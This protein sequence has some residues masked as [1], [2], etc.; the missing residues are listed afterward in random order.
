M[1]SSARMTV[2]TG[3]GQFNFDNYC[4]KIL[5]SIRTGRGNNKQYVVCDATCLPEHA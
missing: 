1:P 2:P 3:Q 4:N 5:K